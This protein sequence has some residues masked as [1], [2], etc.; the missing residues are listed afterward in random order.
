MKT[1][2]II[3]LPKN[4]LFSKGLKMMM[5]YKTCW[6]EH[7]S[8]FYNYI[9]CDIYECEFKLVG[10]KMANLNEREGN[11]SWSSLLL[12]LSLWSKLSPAKM[13]TLIWSFLITQDKIKR[14]E[15]N[16]FEYKI[17]QW[18]EPQ[19]LLMIITIIGILHQDCIFKSLFWWTLILF[20]WWCNYILTNNSIR[21]SDLA[22]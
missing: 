10:R 16:I 19:L 11:F 7:L 2:T 15:K 5:I 4:Y 13:W 17:T 6:G 8:Y 20:W 14:G 12:L 1:P 3:V 21:T 22:E 9:M 18:A